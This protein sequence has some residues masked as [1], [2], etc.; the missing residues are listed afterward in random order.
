[1][2]W[3][4]GTSNKEPVLDIY[5][6]KHISLV[7]SRKEQGVAC[8]SRLM[9]TDNQTLQASNACGANAQ[10][11]QYLSAAILQSRCMR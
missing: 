2:T 4:D 10:R 3:D 8:L 6:G 1:M 7:R 5:A 11:L 9:R